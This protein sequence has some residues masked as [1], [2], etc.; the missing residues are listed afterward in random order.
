MSF[1]SPLFL[2]GALV[3]A[4]PI[5]LHLLGRRPRNR[6]VFPA[7][8]LL[9][10]APA[11]E[12]RRRR[13][14]ELLLLALRVSAII[15]VAVAFARPYLVAH[16]PSDRQSAVVVAVDRS[17]SMSAPG[18]FA[19]AVSLAR[20]AVVRAARGASVGLIAFDDDAEV[21]VKPTADRGA[22]LRAIGRLQPGYGGTSYAAAL[23]RAAE[24]LGSSGGTVIVITDLQRDGWDRRD[25]SVPERVV[26]SVRDVGGPASN[27]SVSDVRRLDHAVTAIVRNSGPTRRTGRARLTIDG[28][29]SGVVPFAVDGGETQQ[30]SFPGSV[31]AS[32]EAVVEV[33]DPTGYQADNRAYTLLDPPEPVDLLAITGQ[34]ETSTGSFY[35]RRALEVDNRRF[36]RVDT[37]LAAG[38]PADATSLLREYAAVV[39]LGTRGLTT[40]ASAAL[41]DYVRAGGGLLVT[42]DDQVDPAVVGRLLSTRLSISFTSARADRP[43]LVAADSRHPILQSFD[44]DGLGGTHFERLAQITV[45][46]AAGSVA[47]GSATGTSGRTDAPVS[48]VPLVLARFSDGGPAL[49]EQR[50]GEGRVLLFGS[51]LSNRWNDFPLQ[52]AFLPFVHETARYLAHDRLPVRDFVV[53][54][55]PAGI[56]RSPGVKSAA[57]PPSAGSRTSPR[58]PT[59]RRS[60][61]IVVN[62]DPRESDVSRMTG[63]EF[64]RAILRGNGAAAG[65][66]TADV[67]QAERQQGL[68]RLAI[69]LAIV[70][71]LVESLVGRTPLG[72]AGRVEQRSAGSRVGTGS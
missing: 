38:L 72:A 63:A 55:V 19:R 29:A 60:G 57:A 45:G 2:V 20:D 17:F 67:S 41:A 54:G 9:K 46:E 50:V 31:P 51:D 30:V 27:V 65:R 8:R 11:R 33:D 28:H 18:Q 34:D 37:R 39:L 23:A 71:L 15:L 49:L 52:P 32:G 61:R 44:Q 25:G 16:A 24:T 21:L 12:T 42:L 14:R 64:E 35:L 66:G 68:W 59:P 53:S 7:V 13:L 70:A 58:T 4:L 56:D 1:L 40:S 6:L 10:R 62:V 43:G 26:V 48:G 69:A 36:F 3:A 47:R 5:A 22:A